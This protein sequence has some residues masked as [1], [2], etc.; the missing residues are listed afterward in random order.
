ME[1]DLEAL[2]SAARRAVRERNETIIF[3]NDYKGY[4]PSGVRA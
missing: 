2:E 1:S 4:P 3:L